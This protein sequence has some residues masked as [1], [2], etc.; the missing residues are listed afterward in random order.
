MPWPAPRYPSDLSDEQ[1]AVLEPR[2][3]EAM[4]ELTV[5]AGRPVIHDLLARYAQSVAALTVEVVA[6]TSLH[7]FQVL[8]RRLVVERTFGWPMRYRP[9]ARDYERTTANSEAMIYW[10]TVLIMTRRLARYE[11]G[12][13]PIQHWSGERPR[14]SEPTALSTGS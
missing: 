6:R 12:Q 9:L 13:P 1:W 7:S 11:S 2:A 4:R 5:A 10:A 3:R 14:T 8:R